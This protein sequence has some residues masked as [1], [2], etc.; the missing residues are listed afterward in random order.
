MKIWSSETD[1]RVYC[2]NFLSY[3]RFH[4]ASTVVDTR[5][6]RVYTKSIPCTLFGDS[7]VT[8]SAPRSSWSYCFLSKAKLKGE[9]S[10]VSSLMT[11]VII[12]LAANAAF[13][14]TNVGIQPLASYANHGLDSISLGTLGLHVDIPLY[15][16]KAKGAGMG[17]NVDLV[18]DTSYL[19]SPKTPIEDYGWRVVQ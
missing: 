18:Y 6:C 1:P 9:I 8:S 10:R 19:S 12:A 4:L 7:L 17:V 2:V 11:T 16:H 3:H 14:Q 5:K 15:Q 13:A